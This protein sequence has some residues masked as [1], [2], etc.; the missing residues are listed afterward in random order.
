MVNKSRLQEQINYLVE[1]DKLKN[2]WRQNVIITDVRQENDAEHSWHMAVMV[3]ILSEYYTNDKLDILKALKMVLV[4]DIVEVYA[5]DTFCFDRD[6]KVQITMEANERVAAERIFGLLPSSQSNELYGL[7]REF[8]EGIT[9]EAIFA[10][11]IDRFQ[12]FLLNY[13]TDGH[14]WKKPGVT[15]AKVRSRMA[16]LKDNM[17]LLWEYVENSIEDSIERGYLQ[18]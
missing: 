13:N 6:P 16:I 14:T 1:I 18:K 9:S 2:I 8:E 11:C 7:W 17:P 3:M 4:H 5:G 10:S 15:S 12:P